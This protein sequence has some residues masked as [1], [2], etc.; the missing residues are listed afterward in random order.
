MRDSRSAP[1]A[2]HGWTLVELLAVLAILGLLMS[3]SIYAFSKQKQYAAKSATRATIGELETLITAYEMA[4]GGPP[5]DSLKKLK[6]QADNDVNDGAE[7]LYVALHNKDF[8]RGNDLSEKNIGNSDGDSTATAYHRNNVTF[9]MEAKD[10][11]D[12]PIAYFHNSGY[13]RPCTYRLSEDSADENTREQQVSAQ[14][15]KTTGVYANA[16]GYQLISAGPDLLFG[17]QDD[18]TNF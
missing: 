16:S 10:A 2:V 9:L 8:A 6:I 3:L 18:V 15:S 4:K 7:A 12:N 13:G 5:P 14:L 17:T 11:W 1:A